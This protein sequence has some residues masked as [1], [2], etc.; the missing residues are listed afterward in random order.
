MRP[1]HTRQQAILEII[2]QESV[3]SQEELIE[4]LSLRGIAATQA[5]LSRD[6]KALNIQKIPGEGYVG[7]K[8]QPMRSIPSSLS[9]SIV[10]IEFALPLAVIKTPVGFAPALATYLDR[11]PSAPVMGTIAGDDAVFLAIRKGF[12]EHQT[13]DA[14]EQILPGIRSRQVSTEDL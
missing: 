1:T 10:S 4:K 7:K 8:K 3:Y 14:L 2:G 9:G 5:T 13:L 11:H 12:S 6:L